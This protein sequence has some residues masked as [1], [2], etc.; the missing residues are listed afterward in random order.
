VTEY[1]AG[2]V[3]LMGLFVGEVM[4]RSQGKADPK[5]ANVLVKQALE[6]I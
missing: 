1:K 3:G 4:K 6:N 2:K 5:T